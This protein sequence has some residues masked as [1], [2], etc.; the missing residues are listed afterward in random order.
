LLSGGNTNLF[1]EAAGAENRYTSTYI[2][3]I[4]DAAEL[5]SDSVIT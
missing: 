2:C 5:P 4:K 1:E 3:L